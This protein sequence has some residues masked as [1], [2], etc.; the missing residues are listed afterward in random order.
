MYRVCFF[1]FFFLF[2]FH[3]FSVKSTKWLVGR[4]TLK[5]HS[6]L[7]V[8]RQT[9]GTV[10]YSVLYCTIVYNIVLFCTILYC[11]KLY[12]IAF[13]CIRTTKKIIWWS[14]SALAQP[15]PPK[16]GLCFLYHHCFIVLFQFL[17]IIFTLKVFKKHEKWTRPETPSPP[18]DLL[19]LSDPVSDFW[20]CPKKGV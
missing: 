5:Y 12:C 6:R 15:P 9:K 7:R 16:C 3:F 17:D 8:R 14:K 20:K 1:F 2:F 10:Y 13:Y 19:I 18:M 4:I 11:T